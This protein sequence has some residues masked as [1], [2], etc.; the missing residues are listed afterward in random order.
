MVQSAAPK[1]RRASIL[2][3]MLDPLGLD[4]QV[5]D[6]E[7]EKHSKNV[8]SSVVD[9]INA[10][11]ASMSAARASLIC[12]AGNAATSGGMAGFS[13]R[14]SIRQ[15]FQ[16]DVD[17]DEEQEEPIKPFRDMD[18]G[19]RSATNI[20]MSTVILACFV[21]PAPI[22]AVLTGLP[23]FY[24][25][26]FD[27][28]PFVAGITMAIGHAGGAAVLLFMAQKWVF[29]HP[30]TQPFSKPM[31]VLVSGFAKVG[32]CAMLFVAGFC[33]PKYP[34]AMFPIA[35]IGD[36]LVEIFNLLSFSFMRE[37]IVAFCPVDVFRFWAGMS[38][39]GR[40]GGMILWSFL[41]ARQV[42]AGEPHLPFG[43]FGGVVGI[44]SF[45]LFAIFFYQGAL[46]YQKK[47][48][49][50]IAEKNRIALKMAGGGAPPPSA[51]ANGVENQV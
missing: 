16:E 35:V 15:L 8:P 42:V 29:D 25:N 22:S 7:L 33:A 13:G 12:A 10:A 40:Q 49:K 14:A 38:Y 11:R 28:P 17:E 34:E 36:L 2:D 44:C 24:K 47:K 21:L 43:I 50:R 37:C 19:E 39:V 1:K 9:T 18:P 45:M 46:P 3:M 51:I 5:S 48:A 6:K 27:Q 31:N 32:A 20:L 23:M 41:A 4:S 30:M 26:F